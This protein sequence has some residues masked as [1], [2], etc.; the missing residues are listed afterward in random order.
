M[1]SCFYNRVNKLKFLCVCEGID[2]KSSE[3]ETAIASLKDDKA[4][5]IFSIFGGTGSNFFNKVLGLY[6]WFTN[7]I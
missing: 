2:Y 6:S 4:G 1:P 3:L 5:S 7:F